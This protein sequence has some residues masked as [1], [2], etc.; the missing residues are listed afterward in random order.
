MMSYL[1]AFACNAEAVMLYL[2]AVVAAVM[3]L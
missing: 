2:F 1:L 3:L